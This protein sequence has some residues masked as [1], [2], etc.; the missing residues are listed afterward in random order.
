V[1]CAE[2]IALIFVMTR[3]DTDEYPQLAG[4]QVPWWTILML[5]VPLWDLIVWL[6]FC[7]L[8]DVNDVQAALEEAAAAQ[9]RSRHPLVKLLDY[10]NIAICSSITISMLLTCIGNSAARSFP[11]IMLDVLAGFEAIGLILTVVQ[12]RQVRATNELEPE[13]NE[14][15]IPLEHVIVVAPALVWVE[16]CPVTSDFTCCI[17]MHDFHVTSTRA[18]R[19]AISV[20]TSKPCEHRFHTSCLSDWLERRGDRPCPLCRTRVDC[21]ERVQMP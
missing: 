21:V 14:M 6:I 3:F 19:S 12:G 4:V 15:Q 10:V 20:A 2:L 8:R 17:C 16:G 1:R 13:F 18:V 7:R 5:K 11:A 9:H